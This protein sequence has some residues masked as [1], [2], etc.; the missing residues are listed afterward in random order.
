VAGESACFFA[1]LLLG[2]LQLTL[3]AVLSGCDVWQ[4]A[5][6]AAAAAKKAAAAQ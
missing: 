4:A 1:C 6:K 2:L 3:S 5:K